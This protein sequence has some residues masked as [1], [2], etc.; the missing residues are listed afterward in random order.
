MAQEIAT[1]AESIDVSVSDA[2]FDNGGARVLF[3]GVGG[4]VKVDAKNGGTAI[5]F[6]NI[7]SGSFVPVEVTQVYTADTTATDIVAL[8]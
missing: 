3:V 6:K 5:V 1:I 7:P 2:T 4:D 8:A